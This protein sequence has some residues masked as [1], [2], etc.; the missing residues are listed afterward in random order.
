MIAF[1]LRIFVKNPLVFWYIILI[2]PVFEKC[3][4]TS[5][6][7][8]RS[9]SPHIIKSINNKHFLDKYGT[10]ICEYLLNINENKLLL[11]TYGIK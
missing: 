2:L 1:K 6:P 11:L 7:G 5:G 3:S 8:K 9:T 4:I 10:F